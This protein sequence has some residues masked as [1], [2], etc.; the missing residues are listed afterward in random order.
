L[1]KFSIPESGESFG[2][3]PISIFGENITQ[4][5]GNLIFCKFGQIVCDKVILVFLL[6]IKLGMQMDFSSK[7]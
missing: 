3:F 6:T 1:L 7:S 5:I 4:P 2:D